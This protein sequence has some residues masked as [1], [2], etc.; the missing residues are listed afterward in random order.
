MLGEH[1]Q[2]TKEHG[3]DTMADE[4]LLEEHPYLKHFQEHFH[5]FPGHLH[6]NLHEKTRGQGLG[7]L[8]MSQFETALVE[9]GVGGVHIITSKDAANR[10]FYERDAYSFVVEASSLV[11]MGKSLAIS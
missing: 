8:L 9:R 1:G 3:P 7:N 5:R 10:R 6:I 11:L 4:F 2:M